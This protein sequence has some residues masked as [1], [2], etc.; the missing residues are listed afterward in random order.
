MSMEAMKS[1]ESL[2]DDFFIIIINFMCF[3]SKTQNWLLLILFLK[4]LYLSGKYQMLNLI[5]S[6]VFSKSNPPTTPDY[7]YLNELVTPTE[8]T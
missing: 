2:L 8:Y 4:K 3:I 5:L 6:S 1:V 7:F